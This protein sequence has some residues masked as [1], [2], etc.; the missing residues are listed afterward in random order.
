MAAKKTKKPAAAAAVVVVAAASSAI[1]SSSTTPATSV[2]TP[3]VSR[4]RVVKP[5]LR[6]AAAAKAYYTDIS[7]LSGG[8]A[9]PRQVR[10]VIEGLRTL[11]IRELKDKSSFKLYGIANYNLRA[12]K[13]RGGGQVSAPNAT[14]KVRAVPAGRKRIYCTVLKELET[15]VIY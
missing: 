3:P 2:L 13:V 10:T 8:T 1:V 9:N 15:D 5:F 7:D 14:W 6:G 4:I 11:C 12:T